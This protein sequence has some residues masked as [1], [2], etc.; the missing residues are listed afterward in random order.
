MKRTRT[1]A[2]TTTTTVTGDALRAATGAGI[3]ASFSFSLY[4]LEATDKLGNF[5]IQDLMSQY[6]QA[7]TLSS[8][9]QK[10]MDDTSSGMIGKIG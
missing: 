6:N 3:Y 4:S 9:V 8:S 1:I 2:A 10:K 7:E 5:E